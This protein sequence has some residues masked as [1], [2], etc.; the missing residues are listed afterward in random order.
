M[1]AREA[2]APEKA[3]RHAQ[4]NARRIHA[5]ARRNQPDRAIRTPTRCSVS[6]LGGV[7][8]FH[9]SGRIRRASTLTRDTLRT[10]PRRRDGRR[11][12][13][14]AS[15]S[16]GDVDTTD[17]A[18]TIPTQLSPPYNRAYSGAMTHTRFVTCAMVVCV[19]V[20]S[21]AS[22]LTDQS[23]SKPCVDDASHRVEKKRTF[24]IGQ[25]KFTVRLDR[26]VPDADAI[27][28]LKAYDDDRVVDRLAKQTTRRHFSAESIYIIFPAG[29]WRDY[30]EDG[31]ANSQYGLGLR[32]VPGTLSMDFVSVDNGIVTLWA[33]TFGEV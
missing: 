3:A 26:C 18:S 29:T 16:H 11:T 5:V 32:S 24:K 12:R 6:T 22:T 14:R 1:R 7:A 30:P 9:E 21:H 10:T 15:L 28:I 17:L 4:P 19:G 23:K 13:C 8:R 31:Y 27:A 20:V 25:H 2:R 33:H